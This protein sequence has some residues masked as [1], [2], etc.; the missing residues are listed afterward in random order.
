MSLL[1]E[2]DRHQMNQILDRMFQYGQDGRDLGRYFVAEI[3][4]PGGGDFDALFQEVAELLHKK[5]RQLYLSPAP[6]QS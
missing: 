1:S 5:M 4:K 6:R 2:V 3:N